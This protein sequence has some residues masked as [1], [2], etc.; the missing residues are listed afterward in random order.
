MVPLLKLFGYSCKGDVLLVK[1]KV[2]LLQQDIHTT[3]FQTDTVFKTCTYVACS[4]GS[5]SRLK[6]VLEIHTHT[7]TH[8]YIYI[9][10]CICIGLS[11]VHHL[12][13]HIRNVQKNLLQAMNDILKLSSV[14][15]TKMPNFSFNYGII[16]VLLS[17]SAFLRF[18]HSSFTDV[19]LYTDKHSFHIHLF[20]VFPHLIFNFNDLMLIISLLYFSTSD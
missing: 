7:H 18:I 14:K 17:H 4:N 15:C 5:I 19:A 6:R 8:T 10:I 12:E 1:E 3:S 13:N 20:N 2:G 9:Y 16:S 11:N